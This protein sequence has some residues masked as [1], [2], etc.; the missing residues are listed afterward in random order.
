MTLDDLTGDVLHDAPSSWSVCFHLQ[1]YLSLI[2]IFLAAA[3]NVRVV[4]CFPVHRI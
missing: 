4:I 1:M 2:G 3:V